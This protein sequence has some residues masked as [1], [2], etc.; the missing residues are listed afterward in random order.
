M[1]LFVLGTLLLLAFLAFGT[2]HTARILSEI[3]PQWNLLLLPAENLLRLGLIAVCIMLALGSGKSFAQFGWQVINP[4]SEI[5]VGLI[6]GTVVA[7]AVPLVTHLAVARF[8]AGIYSPVVIQRVMP[9]N[10]RE[11]LLVPL[12][13]IPAVLLEELLFRSLLLGGFGS[14]VSPLL[15]AGIWSVLFGVMHSPQGA[16]GMVVAA[17]LGLLLSGLFF[18][19]QGLIAPCLAH[20]A[21]N[22]VQLVWAANDRSIMD[23]YP[24]NFGVKPDANN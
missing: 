5:A 16:L 21:I 12:A 7:L 23:Q 9:R 8:G 10:R 17:A 3:P 20:Y 22:M 2:W 4:V 14:L 18:A 19:T 13:F 11:W 1:I 24:G 6:I 15:L